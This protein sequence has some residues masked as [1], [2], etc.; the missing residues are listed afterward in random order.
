MT[1]EEHV[2]R[3]DSEKELD[4]ERSRDCYM[5]GWT[6]RGELKA[7]SAVR[8]RGALLRMKAITAVAEYSGCGATQVKAVLAVTAV[9]A[10]AGC[11]ASSESFIPSPGDPDKPARACLAVDE[12]TPLAMGAAD[13]SRGA[14]QDRLQ[15]AE[16]GVS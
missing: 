8:R 11:A 15:A 1:G 13:R 9:F 4:L 6:G 10:I 2:V 12:A 5:K 3:D 7:G 14:A 16:R